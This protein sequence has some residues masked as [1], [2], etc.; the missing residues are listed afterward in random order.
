M[1][2]KG[3]NAVGLFENRFFHSSS[4]LCCVVGVRERAAKYQK[5][6]RQC[7]LY[8]MLHQLSNHD[9]RMLITL[10]LNYWA[11]KVHKFDASLNAKI[12]LD[13]K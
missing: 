13:A 8:R 4:C 1:E 3:V 6:L 9:S 5:S 2:E 7:K 11:L 10:S 12:F